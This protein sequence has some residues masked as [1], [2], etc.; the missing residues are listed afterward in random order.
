[1]MDFNIG[2]AF[3]FLAKGM[4]NMDPTH[5]HIVK[6][7]TETLTS[8]ETPNEQH[9]IQFKHV[10]VKNSTKCGMHQCKRR[11]NAKCRFKVCGACCKSLHA[12]A[13]EC[14][15]N[16]KLIETH[17]GKHYEVSD[18]QKYIDT[19]MLFCKVHK[20]HHPKYY[21][22]SNISPTKLKAISNQ[23]PYEC[24]SRVVLLGIGAD[25]QLGGYS[26][27]RKAFLKGGLENVSKELNLDCERIWKRNLGRDDR[28]I[29]DHGREARYPFLD[30]NVMQ[31]IKSLE[32]DQILDFNHPNG[33]KLILRHIAFQLGLIQSTQLPKRAIQ[34]GSRIAK[35]TDNSSNAK[36]TDSID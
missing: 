24:K 7:S 20:Y 11:N 21:T 3:W 9:S 15:S 18:I 10:G 35:C 8:Y 26:R 2:T 23:H 17:F 34:F 19:K 27:H 32:I 25:E 33:D 1:M 14:I 30:E 28:C 16:P 13:A 12:L 6:T 5:Q 22:I 29:A 36:G 4:G 31:Y